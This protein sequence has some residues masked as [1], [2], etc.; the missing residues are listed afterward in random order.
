M[1]KVT[2]DEDDPLWRGERFEIRAMKRRNGSYPAEEWAHSLD[3]KGR[4]LFEV[5]AKITVAFE[6]TCDD[7]VVGRTQDHGEV[8]RLQPA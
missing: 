6:G 8:S 2:G 5:A 7:R 4:A 1:A 3:K